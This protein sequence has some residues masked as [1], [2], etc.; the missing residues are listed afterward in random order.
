[1]EKQDVQVHMSPKTLLHGAERILQPKP[2]TQQQSKDEKSCAKSSNES[3]NHGAKRPGQSSVTDVERFLRI[4]EV[5]CF[6]LTVLNRFLPVVTQFAVGLGFPRNWQ[7]NANR[8]FLGQHSLFEESLLS[9]QTSPT[10]LSSS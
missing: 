3:F 6:S 9:R 4:V 7:E 2:A 5:A 8:R 1:M 10:L